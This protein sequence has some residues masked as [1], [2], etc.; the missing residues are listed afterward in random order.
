MIPST[1]TPRVPSP[2]GSQ[3]PAESYIAPYD[4]E[5]EAEFRDRDKVGYVLIKRAY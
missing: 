2:E 4:T 3:R 5:L 1:E